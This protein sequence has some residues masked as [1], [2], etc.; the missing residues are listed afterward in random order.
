MANEKKGA[1]RFFNELKG[2]RLEGYEKKSLAT[3]IQQ[4]AS[5]RTRPISAPEIVDI[6]DYIFT[7][8]GDLAESAA[9]TPE[10]DSGSHSA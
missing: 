3:L 4:C 6:L 1:I 10:D 5:D 2:F 8:A 9:P 7:D